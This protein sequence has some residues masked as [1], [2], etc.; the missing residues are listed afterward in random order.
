[1][2]SGCRSNT[3]HWRGNL[4]NEIKCGC[5]YVAKAS[6]KF[7]WYT[8]QLHQAFSDHVYWRT[9]CM[10]WHH[11]GTPTRFW[12]GKRLTTTIQFHLFDTYITEVHKKLQFQLIWIGRKRNWNARWK[13]IACWLSQFSMEWCRVDLFFLALT[14]LP[15]HQPN[16]ILSCNQRFWTPPQKSLCWF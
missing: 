5:R 2:Y 1:M 12:R 11:A 14:S 3:L 8:Q 7:I 13:Q 4:K 6:K 10:K 16:A 9:W 15:I